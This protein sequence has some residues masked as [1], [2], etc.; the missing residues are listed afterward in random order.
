MNGVDGLYVRQALKKSQRLAEIKRLTERF[1]ASMIRLNLYFKHFPAG[2][3]EDE[4]KDY[5]SQFGEIKSLRLMRKS[6]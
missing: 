6:S 2:S 5:F 4:L 1:K 3:T